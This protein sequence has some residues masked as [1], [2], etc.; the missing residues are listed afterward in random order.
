MK[1]T[2]NPPCYGDTVRVKLGS[3]YHFGIYV[4]DD[5]VI[6]FG[7][8]PV[9]AIPPS[10]T[11]KV[12]ATGMD[13]FCCDTFVERLELTRAEK[14][15]R[16]SAEETVA[17]ARRA[18][19]QGGYDVIH[20]NCEHFVNECAC[21]TS[22]SSMVDTVREEYKKSLA[23][24]VW[25]RKFPFEVKNRKIACRERRREIRL[26]KNPRVR[27]E[28]YYAW[29]LL[30]EAIEALWGVPARK[31]R[32]RRE[33]GGRWVSDVSCFSISH[34]QS[35]VAVALSKHPVG[36]DVEKADPERFAAIPPERL[37]TE[38]ELA[39]AEGNAPDALKS[40]TLKEALYKMEGE[41]GFV[42]NKT[43]TEG[44]VSRSGTLVCDG[45]E[46]VLTA[47]GKNVLL[48]KMKTDGVEWNP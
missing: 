5:E 34:S 10:D 41:G 28:K 32:F 13:V 40:W 19:G 17:A 6:Q 42:P 14:K 20:H 48:M 18:I 11:V 27:E 38:R 7:L 15:K 33:E 31:V 8:P 1:W 36:V 22:A 39:G 3:I 30:E 37:Y 29:K 25:V 24:E 46:Y 21:G 45:E 16:R 44:V 26:C 23:F 2:L 35:V 9:G 43:E 4:S 47:V 12:L